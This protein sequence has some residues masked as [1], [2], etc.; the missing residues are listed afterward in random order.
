[1]AS[2]SSHPVEVHYSDSEVRAVTKAASVLGVLAVANGVWIALAPADGTISVFGRQWVASDLTTWGPWLLVVG[3]AITAAAMAA[4]AVLD[5]RQRAKRWPIAAE[6]VLAV[7]GLAA[8]IAG[9][10][11]LA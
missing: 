8:M 5:L 3:G 9:L 1:M 2:P 4:Y 11:I 6:L 10:T 7:A